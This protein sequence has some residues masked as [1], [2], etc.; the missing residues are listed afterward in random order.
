MGSLS[1]G[2]PGDFG[3]D[4]LVHGDGGWRRRPLL[5]L[6]DRLFGKFCF[7]LQSLIQINSD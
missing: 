7:F 6:G 2:S 3:F 4:W 1:S 5:L